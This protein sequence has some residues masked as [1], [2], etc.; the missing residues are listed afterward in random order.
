M[1]IGKSPLIVRNLG[2]LSYNRCLDIQRSLSEPSHDDGK[3][4]LLLVEHSSPIFTIG[5]NECK[6]GVNILKSK[7]SEMG[8]EVHN[9]DKRGNGIVWH[10]PG[11]LTIYPIINNNNTSSEETIKSLS[12]VVKKTL[13][14]L[15]ITCTI[16]SDGIYVGNKHKIGDFELFSNEM[17]N[18]GFSININPNLS[19]YTK[20]LESEK[21]TSVWN[22][23]N[24]SISIGEVLPILLQNFDQEYAGNVIDSKKLYQMRFDQSSTTSSSSSRTS[25]TSTTPK[26]NDAL[27]RDYYLSTQPRRLSN[28]TL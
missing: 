9:V 8:V 28:A 13:S 12:K 6:D 22:H 19:Y 15:G 11:Q 17:I 7:S 26:D 14:M 18:P 27:I 2:R 3:N 10:G 20:L 24:R 5:S 1:I 16:E 4:T 23:T 21:N 25:P